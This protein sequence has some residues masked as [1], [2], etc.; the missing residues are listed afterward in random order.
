MYNTLLQL[1]IAYYALYNWPKTRRMSGRTKRHLDEHFST[2]WALWAPQRCSIHAS[3]LRFRLLNHFSLNKGT[4]A[5]ILQY[6]SSIHSNTAGDI[7]NIRMILWPGR[8]GVL[9]SIRLLVP[10]ITLMYL[11]IKAF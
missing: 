3:A 8:R 10:C 1:I 9:A 7:N 5:Y 4:L 2:C 6:Y 11:S